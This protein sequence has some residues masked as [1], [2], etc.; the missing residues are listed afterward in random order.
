[1]RRAHIFP[2]TEEFEMRAVQVS[3]KN[4]RLELAERELPEPGPGEVR[5]EIRAAAGASHAAEVT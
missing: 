3:R 2:L 4:G 5:L 1:M